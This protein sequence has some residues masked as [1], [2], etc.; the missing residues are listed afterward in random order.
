MRLDESCIESV[1]GAVLRIPLCIWS[2]VGT[3]IPLLTG[4]LAPLK[5]VLLLKGLN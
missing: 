5:Q 2:V 3:L 4:Q 1:L